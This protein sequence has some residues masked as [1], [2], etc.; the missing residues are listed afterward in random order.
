[1][2]RHNAV[3]YPQSF[4]H[5]HT[6]VPSIPANTLLCVSL[7][8]QKKMKHT[9]LV[10]VIECSLHVGGLVWFYP[11]SSPARYRTVLETT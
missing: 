11:K 7:V 4:F 5:Y 9:E 1:M 10:L 6:V 3:L 2:Y 8:H